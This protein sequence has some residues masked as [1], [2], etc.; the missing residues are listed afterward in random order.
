LAHLFGRR[1]V[2]G[3]D[4]ADCKPKE[5]AMTAPNATLTNGR[6]EGR[7]ELPPHARGELVLADPP[8][9]GWRL[10]PRA[11]EPASADRKP[12]AA[13]EASGAPA[14]PVHPPDRFG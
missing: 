7:Y 10:R 4:G 14:R 3:D 6:Y 5:H 8:E 11:N 2:L 13:R 9:A 1:T 12:F